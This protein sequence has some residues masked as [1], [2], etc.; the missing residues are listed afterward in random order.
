MKSNM[1]LA[2]LCAIG[3]AGCEKR[4]KAELE[5][6]RVSASSDLQ[7]SALSLEDVNLIQDDGFNDTKHV[8][9]IIVGEEGKSVHFDTERGTAPEKQRWHQA[10]HPDLYH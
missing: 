1:T 4:N 7:P 2:L 5:P 3:L 9:W 8:N 10:S 6:P